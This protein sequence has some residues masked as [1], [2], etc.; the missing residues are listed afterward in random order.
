ME[1]LTGGC[2][3]GNIHLTMTLSREPSAL[4]P[5]ACDCDFCQK[6]GAE[7]VSDPLGSLHIRIKAEREVSRFRQGS[8]IAELLLCRTCGVLV[9]A[10]YQD[11]E[12]LFGTVNV[13]V[14]DGRADFGASVTVSP[15]SLSP[16]EKT[17]RWQQVWFSD[18]R[19]VSVES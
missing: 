9:A 10:L 11:G 15:K 19:V 1:S 6:H 17:N 2:Y 16:E 13:K 12:Q 3:C 5:R 14:L 7:Y 4:D 18:V 8:D